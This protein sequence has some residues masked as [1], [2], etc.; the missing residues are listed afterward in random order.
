MGHW[1][2]LRVCRAEPRPAQALTSTPCPIPPLPFSFCPPPPPPLSPARLGPAGPRLLVH[3][4]S[5]AV[6]PRPG[7]AAGP[8]PSH[9]LA[10]C[11]PRRPRTG[12]WQR[13]N[14][15]CQH[16]KPEC[17]TDR[18][19]LSEGAGN[20]NKNGKKRERRGAEGNTAGTVLLLSGVFFNVMN[21]RR[22]QAENPAAAA[23]RKAFLWTEAAGRNRPLLQAAGAAS[24]GS[25]EPRVRSHLSA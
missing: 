22:V 4:P 15:P 19:R 24:C 13:D 16:K 17:A 2:Q 3:S 18:H 23:R 11:R 6:S 5:S 7:P 12:Y 21:I 9:S 1:E 25:G 20:K 8:G 10:P 14:L